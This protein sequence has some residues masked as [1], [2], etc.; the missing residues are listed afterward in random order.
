MPTIFV[1]CM[2]F[3]CSY[4][5]LTVIF[6]IL[7]WSQQPLLS[8]VV[9]ILGLLGLIV[10]LVY[11]FGLSR[12]MEPTQGKVVERQEKG[13]DVM[14]YIA[15]YIVPFATFP[16]GGWQQIASFLM[17]MFV[18]GVIYVNSEMIRVNPVLNIIG[19]RLYEVTVENGEDSVSLITRR[20]RVRRGDVIRFVDVGPGIFLEKV[21]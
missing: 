16:L 21:A 4:F 8:I 10:T 13:S 6:G 14:G 9:V 1:R 11:V 20:R 2:L 17:F 19:Y 7:Y 5:P 18:L 12:K 15:G 3:I